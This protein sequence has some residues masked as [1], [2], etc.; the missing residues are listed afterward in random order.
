MRIAVD[1]MGGDKG[2]QEIVK[3]VLRAISDEV[4]GEIVLVGDKGILEEAIAS[5]GPMPEKLFIQHASQVIKMTDSPVVAIRRKKDSSLT[6]GVRLVADKAADALISSGNTGAIVAAGTVFL[7]PIEGV[8]RAGIAASF[9]SD[10]EKGVCVLIDAGANMKCKPVH[11]VQYA[12]VG[13]VYSKYVIGVDKPRVALLNVGA[14]KAKGTTLIKESYDTLSNASGINFVGNIEGSEVFNGSCD[15]AVTEGF[16]GNIVLK[17]T[18][19]AG[20]GMLR[21]LKKGLDSLTLSTNDSSDLPK[22]LFSILNKLGNYSEYG[23]APLLGLDGVCIKCH[24]RS[25]SNA[26]YNAIKITEKL[27]LNNV[28]RHI[29]DGIKALGLSW[30]RW[31]MRRGEE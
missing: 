28:N 12:L 19:G 5:Q 20:E 15:V 17:V 27:I 22:K 9:P 18:E 7:K 8:R 6:V 16:V 29:K 26:I 24:G 25:D 30:W 2:P 11:L 13:S 21:W 10:T 14:E 23:G 1:A 3:G 31:G 4:G